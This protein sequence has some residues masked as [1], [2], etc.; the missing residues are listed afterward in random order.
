MNITY[1]KCGDYLLPNLILAEKENKL[2]NKYGLLR[3]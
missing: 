3:L 1:T 2:L